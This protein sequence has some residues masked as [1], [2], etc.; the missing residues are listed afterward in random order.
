VLGA[1]LKREGDALLASR[2]DIET[3]A[4]SYRQRLEKQY[5]TMDSRIGALKATQSYLDQQIQLWSN[6][7]N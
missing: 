4:E 5:S 6:Q 3:R 7:S 2:T 1:R